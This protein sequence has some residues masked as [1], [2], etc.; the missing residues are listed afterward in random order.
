[1]KTLVSTVCDAVTAL[2][3]LALGAIVL[4]IVL[5]TL[6]AVWWRYVLD[7]PISWIEQ[8][9]NMLF[10]WCIFLGAA[11]LY[12]ERLHIGVDF[13][14]AMLPERFKPA[15]AWFIEIMNIV[16][17]VVLLVFSLKLS[18]DVLPQ[19]AGA[20]EIT[21]AWYYFSAPVSCSMMLLYFVEKLVDPARRSATVS[22]GEF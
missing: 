21:P 16:F 5:I 13:F 11:V 6:A 4:A 10:A 8:V 17:I 18:I 7:S 19:T 2:A 3:R 1:M 15:M 14:L 20:L 12:R 9:S 22:S